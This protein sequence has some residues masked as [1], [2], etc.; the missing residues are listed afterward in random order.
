M[1]TA[2]V[3]VDVDTVDESDFGELA[4]LMR[5]LRSERK[6]S[7]FVPVAKLQLAY[8]EEAAARADTSDPAQA[9]EIRRFARGVAF[10]IA[11]FT[12]PGWGDSPEPISDER[13]ELGLQ[14]AE[15]TVELAERIGEVTPNALWI[16]GVHQLNAGKYDDAISSFERAKGL[17]RNDFYR[18]MHAAWQQLTH[19]VAEGGDSSIQDLEEVISNLR[20]SDDENAYFFADQLSTASRVYIENTHP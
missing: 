11:S 8:L 5:F 20:K 17:A 1:T 14:A 4:E 19:T 3:S 18:A 7:L 16:L 2:Q 13:Q 6:E 12:W 10:N 9:V 15:R